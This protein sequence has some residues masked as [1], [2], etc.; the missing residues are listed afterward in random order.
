MNTQ[1]KLTDTDN[2]MAVTREEEVKYI[3][4]EDNQTW[5]GAHTVQYTDN[6]RTE[7]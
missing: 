6:Y 1:N 5:S 4:A 7:T 2:S 3:V